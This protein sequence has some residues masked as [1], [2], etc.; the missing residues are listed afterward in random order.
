MKNKIKSFVYQLLTATIGNVLVYLQPKKAS[1]LSE[2][3]MTLVLD[4]SMGIT[5]RLMRSAI[6]KKLENKQDY[7]TIAELHQNYWA[8]KG[9]DFFSKT[10]AAFHN[11]FLPNCSFI[12]DELEKELSNSAHEFDTIVEIGTGSGSVLNYLSSKFP[13]IN[14]FV[15]IDLSAVQIDINTKNYNQNTKLEFVASDGF[16]WVKKHG[17]ENTIFVTSRGVLE[18]FT[19]DRLQAFLKEIHLLGNTIFVAIEPKGV[20]HNYETNPNTQTYGPERSFSHNYPK[21]FKNAG[22]HLWHLSYKPHS[23]QYII[24]SFIGARN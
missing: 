6:L 23:S 3:G 16:D 19:E 2:N 21:L 22:F 15:G 1:Q 14:H 4:N 7:D 13:N 8:N 17:K 12:F 9:D 5:D 20:D 10:E 18:Y 24:Q 11:D